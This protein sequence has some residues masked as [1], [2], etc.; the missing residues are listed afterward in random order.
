MAP[1]DLD[2]FL[3]EEN[4]FLDGDEMDPGSG[5]TDGEEESEDLDDF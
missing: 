4:P 3:D 1:D 5:E 2:A